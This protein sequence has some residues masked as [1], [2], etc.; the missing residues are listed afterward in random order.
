MKFRFFFA[1][2]VTIPDQ[3]FAHYP[4]RCSIRTRRGPGYP[5][6]NFRKMGGFGSDLRAYYQGSCGGRSGDPSRKF[7]IVVRVHGIFDRAREGDRKFMASLDHAGNG[8]PGNRR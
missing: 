6:Q 5:D 4:S 7:F 2:Y 3:S 8:K 1:I